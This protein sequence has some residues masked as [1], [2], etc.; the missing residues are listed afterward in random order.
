MSGII[1]GPSAALVESTS[2]GMVNAFGT[3]ADLVFSS[4]GSFHGGVWRSRAQVVAGGLD[5]IGAL[6]R[7][8][9]DAATV[10]LTRD[11]NAPGATNRML[12]PLGTVYQFRIEIACV[13][14]AGTN[15]GSVATWVIVGALKNI[16]GTTETVG[17][18]EYNMTASD[19]VLA[20]S[21][22]VFTAD[23]GADSLV[24]NCTGIV[25]VAPNTFHWRALLYPLQVV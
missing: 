3:S 1:D 18:L 15:I 16:G 6:Y 24:L 25:G 5:E 9:I 21:M 7:T 11:G 13:C 14:T 2:A 23:D 8:S 19:P 4:D 17:S 22:V 10:E 20:A 12:I